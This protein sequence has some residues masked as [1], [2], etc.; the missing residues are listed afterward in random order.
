MNYCL[1]LKTMYSILTL[2][3]NHGHF[4]F[5]RELTIASSDEGLIGDSWIEVRSGTRILNRASVGVINTYAKKGGGERRRFP[6]TARSTTDCPGED[7]L[8]HNSEVAFFA[9]CG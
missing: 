3:R 7:L 2:I 8:N 5:N 9:S 6:L 4:L 1:P